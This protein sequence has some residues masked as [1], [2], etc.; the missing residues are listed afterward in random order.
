VISHWGISGGRF[1]ELA[2]SWAGKVHFVQTYSF[3]GQ[4]KEAGKKVLAALMAKYPD[5]KGPGDVAPPVGVA[6]AYDAM[7]LTALAIDKAGSTDGPAVRD[8]FLG[9]E[10]YKGL[11]KDYAK[12]F[13][14]ANHDALNENDYVMVRYN[15]E[16]I[17]PVTG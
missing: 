11:I 12:P 3:F 6:N 4:Q 8:G 9:I 1:P 10:T 13:S 2:G 15:G 5:I 7:Q 16:Q 17:E 14:D